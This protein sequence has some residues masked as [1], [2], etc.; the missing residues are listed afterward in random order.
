MLNDCFQKGNLPIPDNKGLRFTRADQEEKEKRQEVKIAALKPAVTKY[1]LQR[2][3]ICSQKKKK[4][5][6]GLVSLKLV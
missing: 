5:N 2:H 3:F 6:Q 1:L 4:K